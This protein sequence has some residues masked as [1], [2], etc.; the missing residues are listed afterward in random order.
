MSGCRNLFIAPLVLIV[1]IQTASAQ[2]PISQDAP[3]C[4][5]ND[6]SRRPSDPDCRNGVERDTIRM[7]VIQ[8]QK[9]EI[10]LTMPEMETHACAAT[11]SVQ[12]TQRN[13]VARVDGTLEN[14]TC[15]ASSGSFLVTVSVRD[16]NGDLRKQEFMQ[17]WQRADDQNVI[18]NE[19]YSIGENVD[20]V[21]VTVS[22]SRCRCEPSE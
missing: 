2:L 6:S 10:D 7:P 15:A 1:F 8:D 19:D 18:F 13:E 3:V 20:L 5:R 21:R 11:V 9:M 14:E 17:S 22:R 12:Y 4:S 16:Q